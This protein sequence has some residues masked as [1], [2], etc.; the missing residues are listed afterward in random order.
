MPGNIVQSIEL[1]RTRLSSIATDDLDTLAE[2]AGYRVG[3][4]QVVVIDR[5][6]QHDTTRAGRYGSVPSVPDDYR[7]QEMSVIKSSEFRSLEDAVG[8][9]AIYPTDSEAATQQEED[10]ISADILEQVQSSASCR[11]TDKR[12][13]LISLCKSISKRQLNNSRRT[14]LLRAWVRECCQEA[15]PVAKIVGGQSVTHYTLNTSRV[16][17]PHL[18]YIAGKIGLLVRSMSLNTANNSLMI[19]HYHPKS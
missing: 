11:C 8:E 19:L 7:A 17:Y 13:V 2:E 15:D 14:K 12:S 6:R 1:D 3:E 10:A 18:R 4:E 5:L 9:T 16:C